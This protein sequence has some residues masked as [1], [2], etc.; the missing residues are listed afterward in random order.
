MALSCRDSRG[1]R[2]LTN[3]SQGEDVTWHSA[4]DSRGVRTLTNDSQGEDVTWHS[5]AETAEE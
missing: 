4:A 3:D 2:T 5:A 1:V